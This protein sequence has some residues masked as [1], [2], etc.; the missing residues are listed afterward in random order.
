MDGIT[1][2]AVHSYNGAALLISCVLANALPP[3]L[4]PTFSVQVRGRN[5]ERNSTVHDYN[6]YWVPGSLS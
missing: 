3:G 1:C 4:F 5:D 2:S 6:Q